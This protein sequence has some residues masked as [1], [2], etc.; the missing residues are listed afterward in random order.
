MS[1]SSKSISLSAYDRPR[2]VT[3]HATCTQATEKVLDAS[4][5]IPTSNPE[6]TNISCQQKP[7]NVL[8]SKAEGY[9]IK[10]LNVDWIRKSMIYTMLPK[11]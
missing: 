3:E 9:Y 6:P 4:N 10:Q 2:L 11:T 8:V 7:G 5:Y 1:A